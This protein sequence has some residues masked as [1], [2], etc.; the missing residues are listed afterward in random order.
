[1]YTHNIIIYYNYY[2]HEKYWICYRL[3]S[4]PTYHSIIMG[5]P[6]PCSQKG[7]CPLELTIIGGLKLCWNI[8]FC[9]EFFKSSKPPSVLA[10]RYNKRQ[11]TTGL[12][13]I[14][15]NR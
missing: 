1:M 11:I 9:R 13:T 15:L 5:T 10:R 12:D 2:S 7:I 6:P 14:P 3:P 4:L 8:N